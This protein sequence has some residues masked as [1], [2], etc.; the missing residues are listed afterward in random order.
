MQVL[1]EQPTASHVHDLFPSRNEASTRR[2]IEAVSSS[3]KPLS[4]N[5]PNDVPFE[6]MLCVRST[7]EG[8]G[9]LY[10]QEQSLHE[11]HAFSLFRPGIGWL[12]A[13]YDPHIARRETQ[14]STLQSLHWVLIKS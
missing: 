4:W 9:H 13:S 5:A 6:E 14:R 3:G 7:S 2:W 1:E 10:R 8:L 11:N 12:R